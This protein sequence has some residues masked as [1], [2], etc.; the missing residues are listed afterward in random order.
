M[1]EAGLAQY[2]EDDLAVSGGFKPAFLCGQINILTG[3]LAS[4]L[5]TIYLKL[6][7]EGGKVKRGVSR[8]ESLCY[9]ATD[10]LLALL[11]LPVQVSDI[12]ASAHAD[13]CTI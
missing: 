10:G 13:E 3:A 7:M 6:S 5:P 1:S 2:S 12:T 9:S 8:V 4:A 11:E